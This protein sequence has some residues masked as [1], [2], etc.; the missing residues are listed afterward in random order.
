MTPYIGPPPFSLACRISPTLLKT[1]CSALA[2]TEQ[3]LIKTTLA[4]SADVVSSYPAARSFVA[5]RSVSAT[6]IWHPIVSIYMLP[7]FT[8]LPLTTA[9]LFGRI[10]LHVRVYAPGGFLTMCSDSVSCLLF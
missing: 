2:L 9:T 5:A 3:L 7:L 4:D 10:I 1:F 8:R 6:F